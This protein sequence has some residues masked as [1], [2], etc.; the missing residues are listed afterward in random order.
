MDQDKKDM[1]HPRS[2]RVLNMEVFITDRYHVYELR[3]NN[4]EV[5]RY[6]CSVNGTIAD[7][8]ATCGRHS[9]WPVVLVKG[10]PPLVLDC[11]TG[12]SSPLLQ[13]ETRA[14]RIATSAQGT[15]GV[16]ET[17]APKQ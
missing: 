17:G 14:G 16:L 1:T 10:V 11:S 12:R 15:N 9:C 6:P 2:H 7:V 5:K 3:E 13:T 4:T 8:A